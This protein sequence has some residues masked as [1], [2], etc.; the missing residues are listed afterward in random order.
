MTHA[1]V[2]LEE[3]IATCDAAYLRA[4]REA[5]DMDVVILAR[6]A[7]LSAGQIRELESGEE[8][9]Y[10]YSETIKR[11]A[12]KRVL[13][14]LGITL[15][16]QSAPAPAAKGASSDDPSLKELDLLAEMSHRPSLSTPIA[17]YFRHALAQWQT[18]K[19]ATGAVLLLLLLGAGWAIDGTWRTPNDRP[20]AE[21]RLATQ[22]P[23]SASKPMTPEAKP[24]LAAQPP[25]AASWVTAEQTTPPL[26][27]KPRA[28]LPP[29]P[30][31]R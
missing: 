3:A 7:C 18:H 1:T 31:P 13:S 19:P 17:G 25:A 22:T 20:R 6:K 28:P 14:V 8:G 27:H 15:P 12:Y 26:L 29:T 11:Q 2:L 30:C 23:P 16:P 9:R 10:F 24:P 21:E 5:A 4:L